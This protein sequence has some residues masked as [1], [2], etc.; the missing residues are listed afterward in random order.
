M[1]PTGQHL[2]TPELLLAKLLS[3]GTWAACA[4]I[5]VGIAAQLLGQSDY[6]ARIQKLG[7]GLFVLLPV[8]RLAT[9]AFAFARAREKVFAGVCVLV[10]LIIGLGTIEAALIVR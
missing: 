4:V 9:L 8:A 3:T 6:G 7:I 2:S 10:I 1:T 5:A